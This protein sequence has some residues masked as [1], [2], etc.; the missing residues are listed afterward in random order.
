MNK[1][2]VKRSYEFT[3]LEQTSVKSGSSIAKQPRQIRWWRLI[4]KLS[5]YILLIGIIVGVVFFSSIFRI[6]KVDVQGPNTELSK[7]LNDEVTKYLKSSLAGKNW[8]FLDTNSLKGRLQKTFTGQEAIMVEKQFPNKLIVKTDEQKSA[9]V[10]KTGSKKY[11]VSING[12]VMSELQ[13]ENNTGL[14]VLT[15]SSSLPVDVG[16][17][18]LSRD[19]VSFAIKVCDYVK[20]KSLGP[21][22]IY[23]TETT[24][25]LLVK[26]TAGYEI[27]FN[28]EETPDAQL[29]SL[30]A[31]LDLLASQNKQATQY[32]DLRVPGRAFYK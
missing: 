15:D 5:P 7:G 20:A 27:K 30:Q 21:E 22:Q 10:W 25:E 11:I 14:A 12:R 8:L 17:K 9:I 23:I 26:T 32:I 19:F 31:T 3:P 4:L 16:N 6:D 2:Q 29:R 1:R 18:I 13:G 28:T 24:K